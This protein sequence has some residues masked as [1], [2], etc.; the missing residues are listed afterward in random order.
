MKKCFPGFGVGRNTFS[1]LLGKH[2]VKVKP[3]CVI[4][5]LLVEVSHNLIIIVSMNHS[6]RQAYKDSKDVAHISP[7]IH[8]ISKN[9][10]ME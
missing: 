10:I 4:L 3:K 8:R 7:L 9:L 2:S 1:L 6:N 5:K